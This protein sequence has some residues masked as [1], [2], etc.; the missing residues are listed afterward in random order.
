MF[1]IE[2]FLLDLGFVLESEYPSGVKVYSDAEGI[3]E[4][5]VVLYTKHDP[6][7]WEIE[8]NYPYFIYC[9]D[10]ITPKRRKLIKEHQALL[11]DSIEGMLILQ[12][13]LKDIDNPWEEVE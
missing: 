3:G 10:R 5:K 11:K 2:K 4:H 13:D 1:K 6:L 7:T 9:T 12:K 8:C